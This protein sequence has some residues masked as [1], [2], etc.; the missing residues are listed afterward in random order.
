MVS[1]INNVE[2][3]IFQPQSYKRQGSSKDVF[4]PVNSF[5]DEDEAIISSQAKLLNELDK[6][7]SGGDN[8]VDLAIANVT[9]KFTVE[10]EVNVI[11]TEKEMMD[12]ILDIGKP[13]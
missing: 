13:T 6:F 10:A 1:N 4:E 3:S 9:S 12:C 7:N 2:Q 8:I 11:Q 5:A